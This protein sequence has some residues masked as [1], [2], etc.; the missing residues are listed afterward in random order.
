M[1]SW[2]ID[3]ILRYKNY[4]I[5]KLEAKSIIRINIM[6]IKPK[7]YTKSIIRIAGKEFLAIKLACG[8]MMHIALAL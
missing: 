6:K 1:V 7:S 8:I 2:F 5:L 4:V 3:I